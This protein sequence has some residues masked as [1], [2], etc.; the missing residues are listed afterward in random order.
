MSAE[1]KEELRREDLR[2]RAKGLRLKITDAPE[3]VADTLAAFP[4]GTESEREEILRFLWQIMIHEMPGDDAV[5]K[6]VSLLEAL[7][8]SKKTGSVLE[9]M[10]TELRAAG[11]ED[12]EEKKRYL[13]REKKKLAAMGISGSAVVPKLPADMKSGAMFLGKLETLKKELL[14]G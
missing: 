3:N 8:H 1:E 10:K 12:E 2:K 6:Y 7:P 4:V 11:H 9:R 14:A 5:F 13:A